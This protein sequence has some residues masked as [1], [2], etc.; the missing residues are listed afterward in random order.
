MDSAGQLLFGVSFILN[1]LVIAGLWVGA[2]YETPDRP[3]WRSLAMGWALSMLANVLWILHDVITGASLPPLSA[4]D[5]LY[6]ARY[7]LVWLAFW[8]Y[9]DSFRWRQAWGLIGV[10]VGTAAVAWIG[11]YGL[12]WRSTDVT[13]AYFLGVAVYPILDAGLI[14]SGAIR[15]WQTKTKPSR[16]LKGTIVASLV[17]YG[18][19]NWLNFNLRMGLLS[20]MSLWPTCF[21]ML[22][23]LGIAAATTAY[24]LRQRSR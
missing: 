8:W 16:A 21:W 22:C 24:I 18:V 13:L 15:A 5:G 9:P 2:R 14:Y 1:L 4:V 10:V 3:F 20:P 7:V 17:M 19:A 23:D 11:H 6:L 12:V